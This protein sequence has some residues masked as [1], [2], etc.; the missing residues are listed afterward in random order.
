[1]LNITTTLLEALFTGWAD[2]F[3]A[4]GDQW[5]LGV[6]PRPG[7]AEVLDFGSWP[8]VKKRWPEL[9]ARELANLPPEITEDKLGRT[10][11]VANERDGKRHVWMAGRAIMEMIRST[12]L[13]LQA[14]KA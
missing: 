8:D 10:W 14:R 9:A 2:S 3:P 6:S 5:A 12:N 11:V 1:M 13:R 4:K 7:V